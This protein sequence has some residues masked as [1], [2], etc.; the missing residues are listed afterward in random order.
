LIITQK[1]TLPNTNQLT[2]TEDKTDKSLREFPEKSVF[3]EP[4]ASVNSIAEYLWNKVYDA[5]QNHS[6]DPNSEDQ[7]PEDSSGL[8]NSE[9]EDQDSE[10]SDQVHEIKLTSN[11]SEKKDS[12]PNPVKT[13]KRVPMELY[14]GSRR[15]DFQKSIVH[16]IHVHA[17]QTLLDVHQSELDSPK[18]SFSAK[19]VW[20]KEYEIFYKRVSRHKYLESSSDGNSNSHSNSNDFLGS[21]DFP[22]HCQ[23]IE[24]IYHRVEDLHQQAKQL[25]NNSPLGT[26]LCLLQVCFR[27]TKEIRPEIFAQV[28]E[29]F[30][31][32]KL[33]LK[34]SHQLQD[35]LSI[36]SGV[37]PEW[38]RFL[39]THCG[40]LFPFETKQQYFRATSLGISRGLH[41]IQN[42]SML[43]ATQEQTFKVGRIQRKKFR[44]SRAGILESAF[45][46]M[47]SF[48]STKAVLELEF[49]GEQG[50]GL[51]PTLEFF[52]LVSHQV[53]RAD[54]DLWI[55]QS[56]SM[57][58]YDER[59]E[60]ELDVMVDGEEL[61][62]F[63]VFHSAGLFPRPLLSTDEDCS[64]VLKWFEF[65]GSFL[66]R[67]L[68][69]S[70]LLDVHFSNGFLKWILDLPLSFDD[71]RELYPSIAGQVE[72]FLD[73]SNRFHE[74]Q[75]QCPS[76][77][78][79]Q[80]Q[81]Y[82]DGAPVEELQLYFTLPTRET[83]P[84]KP[85]GEA[86]LVCLE[87]LGD[88]CK[89][90][91]EHYLLHGARLQMQAFKQGFDRVIP[92]SSLKCFSVDDL[93]ILLGG[94]D[95]FHADYWNVNGL[96]CYC[97]C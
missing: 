18:R 29:E 72:K 62:N 64:S 96:L 34:I 21:L 66:A 73:I 53:Q 91:M 69:D 1:Q 14:L 51:G 17:Q 28:S 26:I 54:L 6:P 10:N 37:L 5:N 75:R 8:Q 24:W 47:K 68:F 89:L 57:I 42:L 22:A 36:C 2:C 46:I 3:I 9:S 38:C 25:Q 70:R 59:P 49:F 84:L 35:G 27:L 78:I 23:L 63:Y 60:E 92:L 74:Q 43:D 85:D 55:S 94:Y 40:F 7:H 61:R 16:E 30:L 48:G 86:S 88:Y 90:L 95:C 12:P 58:P 76:G 4:L 80:K 81:F 56:R 71:F 50:T 41:S 19:S 77:V 39:L 13:K 15:L 93:R 20:G 79:D 65:L 45:R 52:T 32:S 82:F 11:S 83:Y 44:V 87:N 97:L 33:L 67:A 31:N